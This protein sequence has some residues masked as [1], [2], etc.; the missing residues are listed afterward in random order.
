MVLPPV[1]NTDKIRRGSFVFWNTKGCPNVCDRYLI[2]TKNTTEN[3]YSS[4]RIT[5]STEIQSQ[6]GKVEQI[7]FITGTRSV[8]KQDLSKNLKFFRVPET[9]IN[10][11]HSILV[12]REFDVYT[13]ILKYKYN[14]KFSGGETRSEDSSDTQPAP[15]VVTFPTHTIDTLPKPDK[16]KRLKES[17]ETKDK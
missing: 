11:I 5:I 9:S 6:G 7:S 16:F 17:P 15:F 10:S 14:I 12:M 2:R 3:Q 4:L 8:D 13:N 1:G